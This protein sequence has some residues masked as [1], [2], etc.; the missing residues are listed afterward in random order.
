LKARFKINQINKA[1][2]SQFGRIVALRGA[3]Q[4]GKTTLTKNL[5][6]DYAFL[7]IEAPV[8]RKEYLKL[9]AA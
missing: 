6:K 9:S 4:T 7:S 1:L 2:N 5:L 3:R 8:I